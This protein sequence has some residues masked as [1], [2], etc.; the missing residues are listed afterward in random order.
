MTLSAKDEVPHQ[1]S[2]L[3]PLGSSKSYS[4]ADDNDWQDTTQ[5][6]EILAT[7]SGKPYTQLLKAYR[8]LS[9]AS[10]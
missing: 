10:H 3:T 8:R 4:N 9:K 2:K 5:G 1:V 6:E 7:C